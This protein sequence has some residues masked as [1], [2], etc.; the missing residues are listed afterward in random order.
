MMITHY[1]KLEL[2]T[3]S[4]AGVKQFYHDQ[5]GFPIV[6]E[7]ESEIVFQPTVHFTLSFWQ[8]AEALTPAHLAFEVA[9][10]AFDQA[11]DRLRERGVTLLKW[12]D[13][14]TIDDFGTG[15]NVYFRDGDGHLLE[16]ISHTY[17]QEGVLPPSGEFGI[18][19]LREVGFPVDD[20]IAFRERLVQLLAVKL[21]KVYDNFTFAIGGTAHAVL[22]SK[23]RKWFPI[24]MTALPP[25]MHV[26]F[27]VSSADF[28]AQVRTA[29]EAKEI[30]YKKAENGGLHV[31]LGG[32][33]LGMQVAS[34]PEEAPA[35]LGLPCSG[36]GM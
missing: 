33:S 7:S 20:V 29:L 31:T 13:G 4:V 1:S 8:A 34:F 28:L 26:T 23:E 25:K 2:Y 6:H 18:L 3:V 15:Q 27:G 14:R 12:P 35:L 17:V 30:R 16:I 10:S 36:K 9:H 5:L 21:D 24:G 19:Y 32:Y 22:A 11:V